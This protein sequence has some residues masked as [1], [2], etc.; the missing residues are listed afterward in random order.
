MKRKQEECVPSLVALDA[1][2]AKMDSIE[3]AIKVLN[4]QTSKLFDGT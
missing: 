1:L 2:E 4:H 3:S